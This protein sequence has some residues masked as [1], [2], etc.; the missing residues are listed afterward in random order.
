[1]LQLF[2]NIKKKIK[3]KE[4]PNEAGKGGR[5][6]SKHGHCSVIRW[7]N[8]DRVQYKVQ[9]DFKKWPHCLFEL[10]VLVLCKV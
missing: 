4:K 6:D 3:G 9:I 1:M 5:G 7:E 2:R 10:I 8:M